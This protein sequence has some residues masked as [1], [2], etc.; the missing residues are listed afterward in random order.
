MNEQPVPNITDKDVKRIAFRDF[1]V[2]Q[3][4]KVLSILS[5]Y[6]KQDWNEPSPRVQLAILKLANGDIIKL[7]EQTK[8]AIEDF[9]D[10]LAEAE[11]PRYSK[12]IGFDDVEE[13]YKNSVINDDWLQYSE[14]L[15]ED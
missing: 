6:G 13:D 11:Y 3:V 12:E 7:S 8:T 4:F 15:D 5:E 14:W 9:R 2:V 10:V 1:G